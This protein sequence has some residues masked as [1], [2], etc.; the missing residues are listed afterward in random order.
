MSTPLHHEMRLQSIL[1]VDGAVSCSTVMSYI[2]N[3]LHVWLLEH[4]DLSRARFLHRR[5]DFTDNLPQWT[6]CMKC[7]YE[8]QYTSLA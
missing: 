5:Q 6:Y 8:C 1:E 7:I 3:L 4:P 2:R